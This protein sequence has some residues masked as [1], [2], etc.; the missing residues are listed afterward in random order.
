MQQTTSEKLKDF[1]DYYFKTLLN[2]SDRWANVDF[3]YTQNVVG[4][5]TNEWTPSSRSHYLGFSQLGNTHSVYLALQSLG[6][7][8]PP[9]QK[10]PKQRLRFHFGYWFEYTIVEMMRYWDDLLDIEQG[11]AL[12]AEEFNRA[13]FAGHLDLVLD[14]T[15][16]LDVKTMQHESFKKFT[17]EPNNYLGYLTQLSLYKYYY[18]RLNNVKLQAGWLCFDLDTFEIKIVDYDDNLSDHILKSVK[19]K[20]SVIDDCTD[21]VKVHQLCG[22]PSP[23]DEVFQS[24]PTGK[25]YIPANVWKHPYSQAMYIVEDGVNGYSKP[26]KYFRRYTTMPEFIDR[27]QK[28]KLEL[29]KCQ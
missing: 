11:I 13:N 16:L 2:D 26:T 28:I 9:T 17:K 6:F 19:L 3:T 10:T 25:S 8:S 29:S 20:M 15:W 14:K 21:L 12:R 4:P 22:F 5:L 7:K 27:V 1:K 23:K 18:E 24:K